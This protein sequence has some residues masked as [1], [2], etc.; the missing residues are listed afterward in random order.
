MAHEAGAL[1]LVDGAQAVPHLPVDVA[2]IGCD[3]YVFSGHKMLGPTGSGV[4][5]GRRE[6]LEAMP[7][8]MGGGDMIR[9]VHLRRSEWNEIPWKFEA[10]TPDIVGADRPGRRG[11]LPAGPRHGPASG[12]TSRSWSRTRWTCCRARCPG[13]ELYGPRR[14]PAGRGG[15]VQPAGHPPPRRGPGAGPVRDRRPRRPPLHDAA[16]RAPGPGRHR[17]R[18][19][20]ASTRRGRTS[21]RWRRACARSSALR[22]G[23]S[24]AIL[25]PRPWTTSTATT[26]WSTTGGPT[27]SGSWRRR[28]PPTRARTRCAVTGSP[29]SSAVRTAS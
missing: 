4:L 12:R 11:G 10:G 20:S 1:V 23:L 13:I 22:H 26:S 5:W 9:E 21:T 2:E 18:L 27:T 6:L 16:P 7:P 29:C 3:F 17:P 15:A 8:F 24:R 14:R 19:A 25:E 28:P